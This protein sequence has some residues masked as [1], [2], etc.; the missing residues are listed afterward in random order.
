M[1]MICL[2]MSRQGAEGSQV[3]AAHGVGEGVSTP[4]SSRDQRRAPRV[5]TENAGGCA[6][7]ANVERET[8]GHSPA[9]Y[10]PAWGFESAGP[11]SPARAD[12]W[13]REVRVSL[14][15]GV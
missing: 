5:V 13:P 14:G 3:V 15:A 8:T 1:S 10:V 4:P 6:K 9:R 11:P 2:A 7:V 12:D